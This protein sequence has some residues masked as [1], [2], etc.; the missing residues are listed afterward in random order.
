MWNGLA[1]DLHNNDRVSYERPNLGYEPGIAGRSRLRSK[2]VK[3]ACALMGFHSFSLDPRTVLGVGPDASME[4]IHE[5]YRA[6]SK[7]HH[8]DVG[9]DE[10]AFRMVARAYEVLKTTTTRGAGGPAVGESRG[11][12]RAGVRTIGPG[13]GARGSA[14]RTTPPRPIRMKLKRLIRRTNPIGR[15]RPQ[16]WIRAGSGPWASS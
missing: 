12:C 2:D 1:R 11:E 16:R 3:D 15:A 9:G 4:E 5:A 14:S 6:K 7:K 13:P 8:P 10:W